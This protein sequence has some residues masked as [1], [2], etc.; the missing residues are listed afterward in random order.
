MNSKWELVI[1]IEIHLELNTKTKMFSPILNDFNSPENQN[2][3]N[4]DLAYSGS[5]PLVNNETIIK[6]IKLA[7]AL[8]MEIDNLVRFDRKNYFYPDLP[9]GYQITQQFFPIGKNG[10][11]KI[12]V[13]GIW[14]EISIERIHLEEDTA[15]SIHTETSTLLNYNRA[16]VPLIEI[17]SH[18]TI[19]SAKEAQAYVEAIRQTALCLN[20]SDAKMNEGSLRVDTN[21]SIRKKG[22]NDFNTRVEIKNLNSI[23]NVEK[24]IDY[25][26]QRQVKLVEE[27]KK[28]LQETR[29]FDEAKLQTILMRSKND[30][31]DYKY[32]P[33][34]NIPDI[35]VPLSV[36]ENTKIEELPYEKEQ[37][38]LS[39]GLNLVQ[40][41]QLLNNIE[42]SIY[43]DKINLDD[44]KR[45]ANLFFATI[46]PFLNANKMQIS[47]LNISLLEVEKMFKYLIEQKINKAKVLDILQLKQDNKDLPLDKIIKD[48]NLFI[49]VQEIS[50]EDVIRQILDENPNLKNDFN[51]NI[52]RNKKY[53]I[54]QIMKKTM[55][56]AN[57]SKLDEIL[58]KL[59]LN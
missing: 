27:G 18:P 45:K 43:F 26:F 35:L 46:I 24:A 10:K 28:V 40:I 39:Y 47:D 50:L 41:N 7:K 38:Y 6:G 29:R 12:K 19:H 58:D 54:G 31:I 32:F 20:I 49:E 55:G 15:K 30:S 59:L 9:K 3:S 48:N 16:G 14:K 23:A 53:L 33:E 2:V 37:K 21:I 5:L 56:K 51:S 17:V 42:Y 34:P 44:I 8:N 22:T 25:E 11:I 1:G 13:D 4:I 52:D 36:I 57:I